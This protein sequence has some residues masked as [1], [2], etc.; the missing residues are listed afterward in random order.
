[1]S[2]GACKHAAHVPPQLLGD[3]VHASSGGRAHRTV[4]IA[5]LRGSSCTQDRAKASKPPTAR[6]ARTRYGPNGRTGTGKLLEERRA[7]PTS[8][9]KQAD[10]ETQSYKG[11]F[12]HFGGACRAQDSTSC[13]S[14]RS[15]SGTERLRGPSSA[16]PGAAR[17]TAREVRPRGHPCPAELAQS[18]VEKWMAS[19]AA[20][21]GGS[22]GGR[23]ATASRASSESGSLHASS[24]ARRRAVPSPAGSFDTA[25]IVD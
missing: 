11:R 24:T 21:V 7:G 5:G 2:P 16:A 18:F 8:R 10:A 15:S 25:S 14:A 13:S 4:S 1:M 17:P 12:G 20:W 3:D 22:Q 23:G 6:W 19:Q 9:V